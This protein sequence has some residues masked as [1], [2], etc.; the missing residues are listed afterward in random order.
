MTELHWFPFKYDTY[1]ADTNRLE[2]AEHGC[3]LLLMIEYYKHGVAL[4]D[5]DEILA[6]VCGCHV[7]DFKN[8]KKSLMKF[9]KKDKK[10]KLIHKKIEREMKE[11]KSKHKKRVNAGKKGGKAKAS[12]A[13]AMLE[14]RPSKDLAKSYQCST[15][16][17][18]NNNNNIIKKDIDKSISK[19]STKKG[20]VDQDWLP[21]E[22]SINAMEEMGYNENDA[23]QRLID[24]FKDYAPNA[25]T[26]IKDSQAIF[27]NFI[28]KSDW[29][30]PIA[31]RNTG[32]FQGDSYPKGQ[33]SK[34]DQSIAAG[35]AALD[36]LS[37]KDG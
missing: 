37:R 17:N 2:V 5:D 28:R 12:N 7:N 32:V 36:L 19:A 14:Q 9:F 24:Y 27:R 1:L 20:L 16:N 29:S 10:G 4:D 18:N 11:G 13:R 3:Y 8:H 30:G 33:L 26:T 21:N 23:Q 35:R 25:N 6:K 22:T 15:N 34:Y 31:R